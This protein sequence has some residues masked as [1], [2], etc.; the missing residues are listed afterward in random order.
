MGTDRLD[1]RP[2]IGARNAGQEV[3]EV[4]RVQCDVAEP[5]FKRLL[6]KLFPDQRKQER[7]LVP[8]LVGYLGSVRSTKPYEVGDISLSGF[9]LLTEERWTPGTEMPIT[10]ERRAVGDVDSEYFT[11]QAT[12]VRCGS[13]GV[14]FSILLSE[15]ESNAAHGNRLR[16]RWASKTEMARFL[17][18]LREQPDLQAKDCGDVNTAKTVAA[19]RSAGSPFEARI[20]ALTQTGSD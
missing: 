4:R 15:S 10:L 2:L 13:D 16:V 19:G 14:G 18:S 12:V 9:C 5:L 7:I 6:R 17:W 8:P 3:V 11:V 20:A 1:W